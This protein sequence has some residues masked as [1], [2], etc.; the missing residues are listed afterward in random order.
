MVELLSSLKPAILRENGTK[1]QIQVIKYD[2]YIIN[3][4]PKSKMADLK[5]ISSL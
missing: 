1:R 2:L 3:S 5:R 4:R